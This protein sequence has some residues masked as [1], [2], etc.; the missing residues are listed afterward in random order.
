MLYWLFDFPIQLGGLTG[1]SQR[2]G[3]ETIEE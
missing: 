2:I 3:L 1:S